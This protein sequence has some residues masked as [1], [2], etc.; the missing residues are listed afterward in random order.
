MKK[1]LILFIFLFFL[2]PGFVLAEQ[3]DINTASLAQL[4][5]IIEVGP[6]TAQKI[7]DA[8]PF[9]SLDDLLSVKGIGPATL[10]KIKDQGIACVSCQTTPSKLE[11]RPTENLS[12]DSVEVGPLIN[13]GVFINEIMPS[14]LGA[15]EQ[16]EWIEIYNSNNLNIDLSGWKI[17]DT[18]G[19]ITNYAF[20]NATNIEAGGFLLLK[21]PATKIML[22]NDGDGLNLMSP[23]SITKDLVIY[24]KAPRNQ[25]YN[26]TPDGWRWSVNFTPGAKNVISGSIKIISEKSGENGLSNSKKSVKN[27]NAKAELADISQTLDSNQEGIKTTNPWFLFLTAIIITVISAVTVLFIKI[28]FNKNHVRT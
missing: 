7:I 9:S 22:N 13:S 10:Q 3:I 5:A 15:D 4:D 17:S 19:T 2:C 11:A 1:V 8:R 20:P 21:R 23:D 26:K 27:N 18:K 24:E 25:S 16:D 6:A 12:P 28:K 14:P